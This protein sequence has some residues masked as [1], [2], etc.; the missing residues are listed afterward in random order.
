M[1]DHGLE[2]RLDCKHARSECFEV[3]YEGLQPFL[4]RA[5]ARLC[6]RKFRFQRCNFFVH[7]R[8]PWGWWVELPIL[9]GCPDH[10]NWTRATPSHAPACAQRLAAATF[11]APHPTWMQSFHLLRK[12]M[13]KTPNPTEAAALREAALGRSPL[14]GKK[15]ARLDVR[16]TDETKFDLTRKCHELGISESEYVCTLIETSLYGVSHVLSVQEARLAQVCGLS[17]LFPVKS[18][19]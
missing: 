15:T 9:H 13:S 4:Q 7:G 19:G 10:P 1:I 2:Q 8:A 16:I 12:L 5:V 17:G 11:R 6:T 14:G 18:E 3:V